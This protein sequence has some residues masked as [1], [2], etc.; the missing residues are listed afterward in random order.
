MKR[1]VRNFLAILHMG[2]LKHQFWIMADDDLLGKFQCSK[3]PI[4]AKVSDNCIG[5]FWK[6]FGHAIALQLI[7][8]HHQEIFHIV[9]PDLGIALLWRK[10]Q[11]VRP[12]PI[13]L[14]P[15]NQFAILV[16]AYVPFQQAHQAALNVLCD[17]A[18][19]ESRASDSYAHK[20][21]FFRS[22]SPDE[23]IVP[24]AGPACPMACHLHFK[25]VLSRCLVKK[26]I[27]TS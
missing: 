10:S 17:G 14:G 3:L 5:L 20:S 18:L 7:H 9:I 11:C 21:W 2:K 16:I 13:Y 25:D 12:S 8:P 15:P 27:S 4:I 26:G 23:M 1:R 6:V 24:P 22:Q 19:N